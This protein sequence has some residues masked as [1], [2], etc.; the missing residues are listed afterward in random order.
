MW[1]RKFPIGADSLDLDPGKP[2]LRASSPA[3]L[4]SRA[5]NPFTLKVS[6]NRGQL[7]K[8]NRAMAGARENQY[9]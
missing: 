1:T 5:A 4:S 9:N 6:A 7:R 2:D 3:V 8:L